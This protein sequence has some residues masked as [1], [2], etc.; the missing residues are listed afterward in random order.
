MKKVI[1]IFTLITALLSGCKKDDSSVMNL[2]TKELSLYSGERGTLQITPKSKECSFVSDNPLIASVSS[3][4]EVKGITVGEAYI[5]VSNTTEN[6]SAKCKVTIRPKYSMYKEPYMGFGSSKATVKSNES[7]TLASE[8]TDG[9]L[10]NGENRYIEKVVYTFENSKMSAVGCL[11]SNTYAS[12][13][14]DYLAERY[15]FVDADIAKNRIYYISPDQKI[16]VVLE[17]V[18]VSYSLVGYGAVTSSKSTGS[19]LDSI[20]DQLH[21][22]IE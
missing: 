8:T 22:H 2:Q 6:F 11:I 1:L 3:A 12:L 20:L 7:R 13:L 15:V 18:S 4:G 10:Y 21:S 14:G 16:A 9:L 17:V 5:T 19:S